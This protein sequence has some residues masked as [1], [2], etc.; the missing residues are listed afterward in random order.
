[1]DHACDFHANFDW[2]VKNEVVANGQE[3]QTGCKVRSCL[4]G[5]WLRRENLESLLYRVEP[6]VGGPHIEGADLE[7][8]FVE[9]APLAR[10]MR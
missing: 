4:P 9:V 6:A 2:P 7:P 1:M 10:A 8:D 5:V 3:S